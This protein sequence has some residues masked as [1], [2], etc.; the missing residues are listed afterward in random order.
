MDPLILNQSLK[1]IDWIYD[2]SMYGDRDIYRIKDIINSIDQKQWTTNQWLVDT[3][4]TFYVKQ[5]GSILIA[6]GWYGLLADI[7]R[8][9][10]PSEDTEILSVDMDNKTVE[11]GRILFDH[12]NVV[13]KSYDITKTLHRY[14]RHDVVI[15]PSC[16]HIDNSDLCDFIRKKGDDA[17][18][19]LQSNDDFNHPAHINCSPSLNHFV[20]YVRPNLLCGEILFEETLDMGNFN[21]FMVVAR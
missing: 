3:L 20:E 4:E 12:S 19:V 8:K 9:Q 17:L 7:L 21:Q 6:G 15:V 2:E 11:F 1:L 5:H 13:F 18:I 16:E 14:H 10:Y